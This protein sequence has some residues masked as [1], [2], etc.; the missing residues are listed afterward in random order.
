MLTLKL[1]EKQA[2]IVEHLLYRGLNAIF[3]DGDHEGFERR[4]F[5]IENI[6]DQLNEFNK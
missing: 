1:N 5:E 3:E 4:Q 6:L 2:V